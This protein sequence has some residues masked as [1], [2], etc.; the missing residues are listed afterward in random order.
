M[1]TLAGGQPVR[2]IRLGIVGAARILPAHL[3]GMKAL[4]D[5]DLAQFRIT[6]IAARRIEDAATFRLRGEGASSP[7]TRRDEPA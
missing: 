1:T 2:P 6:A 3:R 4:L 7:A 5:A